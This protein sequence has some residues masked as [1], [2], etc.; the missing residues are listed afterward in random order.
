MGGLRHNAAVR[1]CCGWPLLCSKHL[2]SAAP[3][4]P[5]FTSGCVLGLRPVPPLQ[6]LPAR[7][8]SQTVSPHRL[9]RARGGSAQ[10]S[11]CQHEGTTSTRAQSAVLSAV[12]LI[13]S[14]HPSVYLSIC[15]LSES[16]YLS[17][18]LPIYPYIYI[19]K[20]SERE[21]VRGGREERDE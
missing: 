12:S 15:G 11:S 13:I 3:P 6:Q 21:R 16:I 1:A 4:S 2:P 10:C 5:A 19:Y 7:G 18:Y 14:I 8:H 20:D 9:H 17:T